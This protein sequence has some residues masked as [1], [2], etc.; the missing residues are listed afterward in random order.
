MTLPLKFGREQ[1][2]KCVLVP[3]VSLGIH[4]CTQSDSLMVRTCILNMG[5]FLQNTEVSLKPGEK[6]NRHIFMFGLW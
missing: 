6:V 1:N 4:I 3:N 2:D 5:F